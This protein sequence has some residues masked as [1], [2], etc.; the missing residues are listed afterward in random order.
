MFTVE[1][2]DGTIVRLQK[3]GAKLV[4]EVVKYE[5]SYKLCYIRGPEQLLLGLAEE[6]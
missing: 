2:L 4:G 1:D 3:Y 6:L 5:N